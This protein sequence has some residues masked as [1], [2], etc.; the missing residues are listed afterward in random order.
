MGWQEVPV[1]LPRKRE[2][3]ETL[4]SFFFLLWRVVCA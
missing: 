4:V 2:G 1:P 3:E